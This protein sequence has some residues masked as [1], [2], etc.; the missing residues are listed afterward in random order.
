MAIVVWTILIAALTAVTCSL[1]GLFLVLKREAL[2]AEGL[3]HAVLPGIVLAFVL[4]RDRSS[5]LL[6]V[7]AAAMGLLMILVVQLIR[8]TGVVDSDASLGVVFP[9]LFSMGILL[10]NAELADTH[11]HAD[12]IIDGN[13][14]LSSLDRLVVGGRDIGP[15]PFWA[16]LTMLTLVVTFL[17]FLFKEMK[18]MTFDSGLA[19]TLGFRPQWL[20]VAWLALVSMTT[21]TAFETAGSVLVV[22]LMIA[23]PAAA[24]LWTH[25]LRIMTVLA[26]GLALVSAILGFGLGYV[27]DIAPN[28]PMAS[29][30]G[31][32]FLVSLAVAP[33]RG[34][35]AR[36]VSHDRARRALEGAMLEAR[37]L[38]GTSRPVGEVADELG[39]DRKRFDRVLLETTKSRPVRWDQAAGTLALIPRR[40]ASERGGG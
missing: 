40:R 23:P 25:D 5:P 4:L 12:C 35:L 13:L 24:Y 39:W 34:L 32:V 27:L 22:A 26:A 6:I 10:A 33:R 17:G 14:A 15:K 19:D 16:M 7:S 1:C 28:G 9:A 18:L 11:F 30:A 2:V 37:L 20:H 21:V 29:M 38:S 36:S 31:L 8:R 3:A